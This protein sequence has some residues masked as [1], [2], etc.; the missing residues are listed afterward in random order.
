MYQKQQ[1]F[2]VYFICIIN[3]VMNYIMVLFIKS[4]GSLD[5]TLVLVLEIEVIHSLLLVTN[6]P[7]VV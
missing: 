2:C 7:V 6:A 3:F 4:T 5:I 1:V